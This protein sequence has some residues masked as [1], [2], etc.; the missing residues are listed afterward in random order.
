MISRFPLAILIGITMGVWALLL[1]GHGWIIPFSFFTPLSIV[2]SVISLLLLIF[3][4][5][6]WAWPLVNSLAKRPDLRGTWKG[7]LRSNWE[8]SEDRSKNN[9]LEVYLVIH[10]TF[11]AL[12]LRLLTAE[13]QSITL[14]A[15]VACE[16][17]GA[18]VINGIYRNEPRLSVRAHS[19]IHHGGL[20]LRLEGPPLVS[21]SGHY[22]TDRQSDGE[23]DLRLRTRKR[24][25][26][27]RTAQN[28]ASKD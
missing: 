24:A 4:E 26:D 2:V 12:H 1:S 18:F 23:L 5:W 27:Y 14:A 25:N 22:W 20:A 15:S 9:P 19:P 3:E 21:M 8:K 10:Q 16:S 11:M 7:E 17:D 28:L 6:A 13:S